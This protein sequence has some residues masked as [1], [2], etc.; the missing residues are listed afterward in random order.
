[1]AS[2]GGEGNAMKSTLINGVKMYSLVSQQRSVAAWL[3]PKKQRALRK[4]I[5]ILLIF[6]IF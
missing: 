3:T 5:G 2:R 6:I 4:N 1:M